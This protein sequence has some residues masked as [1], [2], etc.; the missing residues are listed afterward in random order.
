MVILKLKDFQYA[1][2]LNENGSIVISSGFSYLFEVI[3][4]NSDITSNFVMS[5]SWWEESISSY[6]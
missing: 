3:P 1:Y 6:F 5:F 2:N 4:I